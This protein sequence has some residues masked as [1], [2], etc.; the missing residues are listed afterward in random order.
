MIRH[1]NYVPRLRFGATVD[2]NGDL[3][4]GTII[5]PAEPEAGIFRVE[6]PEDRKMPE[7]LPPL[8]VWG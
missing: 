8:R 5:G 6:L 7:S 1:V 2:R 3:F 4:F